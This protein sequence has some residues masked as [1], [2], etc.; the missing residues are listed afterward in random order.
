MNII[1][2]IYRKSLVLYYHSHFFSCGKGLGL[3]SVRKIVGGKY[4]RIGN[5]CCFGNDIVLTAWSINGSTPCVIIGNNCSFGSWNHIS[6]SNKIV[7]NDGLLTGKWVS[8]IDNS[9]GCS[10]YDQLQ[11][12]PWLRPIVSK[13]PITIGKN[14]WIGDKAT[15]LSGVTIGDGCIIAAN[16][17]V[18]KNIPSY[19]VAGGVPAQIIKQFKP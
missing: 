12:R 5:D 13:G 10:T 1:K 16:S 15:I 7:I 19:C 11:I 4:I 18:T 3:S 6:S 8:I 14:V 17:V 2:R 9:H